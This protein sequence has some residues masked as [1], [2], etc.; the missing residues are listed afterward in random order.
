MSNAAHLSGR[1]NAPFWVRDSLFSII[2]AGPR[3]AAH[4]GS[5]GIQGLD[6]RHLAD[7]GLEA[8]RI[9]HQRRDGMIERCWF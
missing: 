9:A 7:I 8:H 3:R 2:E 4:A 6:D 1:F 5:D